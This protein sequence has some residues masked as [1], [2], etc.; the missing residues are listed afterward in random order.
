M[1]AMWE[2]LKT[3]LR[4]PVRQEDKTDWGSFGRRFGPQVRDTA[5]GVSPS[6]RRWNEADRSQAQ[7]QPRWLILLAVVVGG[8]I[9][10]VGVA[11][12]VWWLSSIPGPH[13]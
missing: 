11:G 10:C 6:V 12:V 9:F 2:R 4:E 8:S 13:H 7:P 3:W 5:E 1:R